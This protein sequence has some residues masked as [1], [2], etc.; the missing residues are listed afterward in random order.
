MGPTNPQRK[1]DRTPDKTD[2]KRQ[3]L[4]S[5]PAPGKHVNTGDTG[6]KGHT[7]MAASMNIN[8]R[9]AA[10]SLSSSLNDEQPPQ[11]FVQYFDQ[12]ESRFEQRIGNIITTKFEEL[13][14]KLVEHDE[15][16][17]GVNHDVEILR[18]ELKK[19]SDDNESLVSKLD[20]IENRARR[21][22]IVLFGVPEVESENV[23]QTVSDIFQAADLDINKLGVERCHRTPTFKRPDQTK[24]R[25]IHIAF[26][27]YTTR[28]TVRK[29]CLAKFKDNEYHGK[30]IFVGEDFSKRVQKLRKSKMATF[31]KLQ[32]EG[33]R[34]FFRL[35]CINKYRV[36]GKVFS[37]D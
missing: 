33:K 2:N 37:A 28:E 30:R 34:P 12:F 25:I 13:N 6:V 3:K 23:L 11:W 7:A 29:A 24:P 20:D 10:R 26:S 21:N 1:V 16:I 18:S 31:K 32:R 22:N 5:S 27:S 15:M 8:T 17:K 14:A 36:D 35:S 9:Q 19:L 4:S